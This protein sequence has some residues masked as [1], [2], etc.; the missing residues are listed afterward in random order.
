MIL[1]AILLHRYEKKK[2][3]C[4]NRQKYDSAE[5]SRKKNR[6]H[7]NEHGSGKHNDISTIFAFSK[8][9]TT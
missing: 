6:R 9:Y 7:K 1:P 8:K 3:R 4:K 5:K 2:S